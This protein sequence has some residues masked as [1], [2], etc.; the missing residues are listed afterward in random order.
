MANQDASFENENHLIAERRAKLSAHRE[1][2]AAQGKSAFPNDFRRDNLS[3]EL[4]D[5]LGDKDKAELE[6]LDQYASVAG[7]V[8]RKRGPFIVIQDVAGQIQLYVDKKGLPDDVLDDVKGWDIGDI[9]AGRGPVHKSGKGDLYVKM[10]DATLLTKS[11]RPLPDKFH[12]LTDQEA[13]Y[14][15]RYVDLIMNPDSRRVFE[16]R[17]A[18]ISAMRRFFEARDFM[19]VETPMLQ[20]IPGGATARPFMTHH[21]A[22]DIDM[23]LRVA[24]ELYL[25]RLVVGGFEKVFEI[26]RNFRNEGL[27]T[28]HN[29]EF[30][31]VEF[32]WAYAD[33]LDL[34]DMTEAM[35]R[36]TAEQVLGTTLIPY[37]GAEYDFGKAFARITLRNAILTHGDGI[38]DADLDTL[39]AARV[40]ADKLGIAVKD[41]WGLGKLQ[42]EIFEE[43][44][45]HKLDQPTFIIE[46]PAEVSP[47]A[48][49]NDAN[50]FV[51][52]RFEFF[53]GGREIANGFSELNDAEDQA[54]RFKEQVAEKDA[55][56]LEAMYY[57]A[58]YVRALEYGLPPTAGEGIGIDRL[59]MLFTDSASIRDV[60]LFPAMRPEA[61]V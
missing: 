12:G 7:R 33:Y 36:T 1:K 14:R 10:V 3:V 61:D 34:L 5:A 9:V 40:L 28:R 45:E 4:Q 39:D 44:A 53:V 25:K 30:T 23:Y 24:P 57:D 48:R 50:P 31:M 38:V 11:L 13:R 6:V 15:Q 59:V 21:N 29:P 42:T 37:Q 46:Y 52:D 18:V 20:Q 17:A 19:E 55:G 51:T 26:N 8:M 43:V 2:T 32:Y 27:S 54:Q 49:R 35:L 60:L 41:S 56:D 47:L 22:L 16:I 58:D